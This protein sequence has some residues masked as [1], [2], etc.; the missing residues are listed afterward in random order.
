MSLLLT[1]SCS[2]HQKDDGSYGKEIEISLDG[3]KDFEPE[4]LKQAIEKHRGWH[5]QFNGEYMD[6]YCSKKCA[7]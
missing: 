5:V 4:T 1:V 6:T 3:P 7:E 2:N